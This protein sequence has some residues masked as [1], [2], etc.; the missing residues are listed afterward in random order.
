MSAQLSARWMTFKEVAA[1]FRVSE[2]SVRLGRGVF[3]RLRRVQLTPNRIVLLRAEV[4]RLDR[5]MER[6]AVA[7]TVVSFEEGRRKSA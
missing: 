3:G 6:A 7:P 5:E 4:E 1:L 2:A